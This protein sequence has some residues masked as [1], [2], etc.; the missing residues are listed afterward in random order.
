[1]LYSHNIQYLV[2]ILYLIQTKTSYVK[3][4]KTKT[5]IYLF[6]N[7]EIQISGFNKKRC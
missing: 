5:N 3:F 1:M 4:S 2:E 7:Y 6:Q